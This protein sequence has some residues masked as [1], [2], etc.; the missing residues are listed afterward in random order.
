MLPSSY[1]GMNIAL[2]LKKWTV[3]S[4]VFP[5][6]KKTLVPVFALKSDGDV[7]KSKVKR[8]LNL[9][10]DFLIVGSRILFFLKEAIPR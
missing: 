4:P 2:A 7:T 1:N 10:E 6:L 3:P 9:N 5:R 8:E